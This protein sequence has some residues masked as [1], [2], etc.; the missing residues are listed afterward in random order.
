MQESTV[1][2]YLSCIND[3]AKAMRAAGFAAS[4]LDE[5]RS[6]ELLKALGAQ[7]PEW[8]SFP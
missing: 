4:Y 5:A 1:K 8:R 7:C 2:I 6:I 3:V